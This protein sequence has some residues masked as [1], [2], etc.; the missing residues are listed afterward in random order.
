MSRNRETPA[1]VRGILAAADK[2][3]G[4]G[5]SSAQHGGGLDSLAARIEAS[6]RETTASMTELGGLVTAYREQT[7]QRTAELSARLQAVEQIAAEFGHGGG[8]GY[9]PPEGV[10]AQALRDIEAN[11]SFQHLKAWNFGTARFDLGA[12]IKAAL[13]TDGMGTSNDGTIPRQGEQRGIVGPVLRPLRLLEVLPVRQT[14][15]DSVEYI[16]LSTTGSAGEQE[17]EGDEK[18]EVEFDGDP[19]KAEIVTIAAHTTASKQVLA[20]HPALQSV[21]NQVINHKLLSR[22]ES[23]LINGTGGQGQIDGF[24]SQGTAF[25]PTIGTTPADIIGESLVRQ[26]DKGFQPNLVVMNPLDWYRLQ[27]TRTGDEEYLF[28]SPT[29][30]V[31]PALWNAAIVVTPSMSEGE[32]M[33][34]DTSFTT[35]LDRE[36]VSIVLSN[37]HA[38]YFTRNLVAIL[39]ELRAGLEIL[40]TG[41]VHVGDLIASS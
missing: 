33:T 7:D 27:I 17:F 9:C 4:L 39:G 31:P 41:A 37:S 11:H 3:G 14:A 32:F 29:M 25:V 30:P 6:N 5:V 34:I 40:D 23:R 21:I 13:T 38:D 18:A 35:V 36:S 1:S 19:K 15:R 20:D 24:V 12:S 16:Q 26:A 8:G 22:L 28:G 10:A 2:Y